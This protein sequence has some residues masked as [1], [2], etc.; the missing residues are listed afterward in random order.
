MTGSQ[1]LYASCGAGEGVAVT[2][3]VGSGTGD[4]I[5]VGVRVGNGTAVRVGVRVM[6]TVGD[7]VLVGLY[8]VGVYRR[9]RASV[10][11]NSAARDIN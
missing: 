4:G 1:N 9:Q 6:V 11:R 2:V 3:A 7:G 10:K 5:L 8:G